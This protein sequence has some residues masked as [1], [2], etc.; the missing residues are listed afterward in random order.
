MLLLI[1]GMYH[2]LSHH[3]IMNKRPIQYEQNNGKD[4]QKLFVIVL[5]LLILFPMADIQGLHWQQDNDQNEVSDSEQ[6]QA[7][8]NILK[9]TSQRASCSRSS[10][11]A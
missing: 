5:S 8:S 1:T 2:Y 11:A 7:D 10:D 4:S 9:V 6:G 3:Y